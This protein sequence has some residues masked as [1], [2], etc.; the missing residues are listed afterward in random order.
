MKNMCSKDRCKMSNTFTS[1]L[2]LLKVLG[3]I[4]A[5]VLDQVDEKHKV[6]FFER[7]SL[8]SREWVI[9]RKDKQQERIIPSPDPIASLKSILQTATRKKKTADKVA[10][11]VNYD[12]FVDL[13]YK[14][15]T[16]D[17]L[18]RI[19]PDEALQ[20]PFIVA[21]EYSSSRQGSNGTSTTSPHRY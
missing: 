7:A 1:L 3:M 4:P 13:I 12:I 21:G 6:Q 17:P 11:S 20:H 19:S 2:L 10:A 16:Y 18:E 15:L 8:L 9:R 5:N 14:M